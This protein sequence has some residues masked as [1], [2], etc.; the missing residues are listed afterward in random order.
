MQSPR[1]RTTGASPA[2]PSAGF[3]LI[4]M[5]V[6]I[7]IVVLLV[8]ILLPALGRARETGRRTKCL[9]NLKGIGV[10]LELYMNTEGKGFLPKVRPLNSGSND[11]DP[12]LLDVMSKYTDA[13][14]P[15][16]QSE[17]N[18]IVSDPWR[19]PSDLGGTDEATGFRPLWSSAGT[20]YEYIPGAMFLAAELFTVKNPHFGVSKAFENA[21]PP[22]AVMVDADDWHN[23]RFNQDRRGDIPAEFR[24]MRN[25]L[26]YGDWRADNAKYIDQQQ[27]ERLFADI[28]QFGGGLGG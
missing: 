23:P 7:S 3:T 9:A 5:L 13:A 25:G 14:L 1:N 16:E 12:S 20:S 26:Y 28:V 18:W 8:S 27:S 6:V 11:N 22:L 17:G 15:F 24:W 4:E 10:G 2:R 21:K 19:C